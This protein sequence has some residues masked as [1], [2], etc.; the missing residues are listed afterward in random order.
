MS[1]IKRAIFLLVCFSMLFTYPLSFI[2]ENESEDFSFILGD[3]TQNS[4]C[5]N[6]KDRNVSFDE[7]KYSQ[8]MLS[9]SP[10]TT[11]YFENTVCDWF[12]YYAIAYSSDSYIKGT[13]TFAQGI[14]E[15]K[16]EFFLE[17]GDKTAFFY[18]FIDGYFS[19]RKYN[20]IVSLTLEALDK[21]DAQIE[22]SG[23]ATF[24]RD[25]EENVVYIQNNELKI[26]VNFVWGGA[27]SY[28][29]D[30]NSNVQAVN[31]NGI[32]KVDSNAAKRYSV[33]SVN[34]NVN[35]INCH[36]TGRLVQQSYYG[37]YGEGV[38]PGVFM[39][40]EWAYNPV[41]GGNL[42]NES[43]KIVDIRY[44]SESIYI[45]CRPLDWARDKE[46]ITPSY[47]EAEYS[48]DGGILN[49]SCRFV[50]FSGYP[51]L[52]RDQEMPAF[53]CIEPFN[54]FYY[55]NGGNVNCEDNLIFW[56]DAGYP[57]FQSDECWVAFAGEFSDS[58]GIGLYVPQETDF[59]AGVYEREKTVNIQ[60]D[61]D[62]ST[63]YVALVRTA[64][65]L[66]YSPVEYSYCVTTGTVSE[67][68]ETFTGSET[69]S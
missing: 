48:L 25:V 61:K 38:E 33:D 68:R 24:N 9:I 59:L 21:Y 1:L 37:S 8:G 56:P 17:P 57:H 5:V 50:D 52:I 53:Y 65:F 4:I 16:E 63:S 30:L 42:N 34:N 55:A 31:H 41:Q 15:R 13:F 40:Q 10:K 64:E 29:E 7:E 39:G 14:F 23:I 3:F 47:M 54:R 19:N 49:I 36:D 18:S 32:I 27:L 22:I 2:P 66:S 69:V 46:F 11:V 12:N 45:K 44:S 62:L 43:S 67:I 26:G 28:L 51:P 6:G 60:P 20:G 35:L 58:F